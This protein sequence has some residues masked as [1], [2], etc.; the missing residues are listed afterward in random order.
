MAILRTKKRENVNFA[1]FFYVQIKHAFSNTV[2]KTRS[3]GRHRHM[4][5]R[6]TRHG[7]TPR[8]A[9]KILTI[10]FLILKIWKKFKWIIH[11]QFISQREK[12]FSLEN[13]G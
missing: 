5:D 13:T 7:S 9:T 3:R 2:Y 1:D 4:I 8:A 12:R 11:K 10:L 6:H